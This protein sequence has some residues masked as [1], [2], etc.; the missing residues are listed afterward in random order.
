MPFY[1]WTVQPFSRAYQKMVIQQSDLPD[2]VFAARHGIDVMQLRSI[3]ESISKSILQR[4][5][6]GD[7]LFA[8]V[9]HGLQSDP[10]ITF[11]MAFHPQWHV[12]SKI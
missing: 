12:T 2:T 8:A 6:S 7:G 11:A 10:I 5:A 3:R 9:G 4:T 1:R